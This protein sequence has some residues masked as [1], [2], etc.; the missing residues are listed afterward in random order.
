MAYGLSNGHVTDDVTWP[1]RWCEAVRSAI[2][3][4]AWLL[5]WWLP[6][7]I[8]LVQTLNQVQSILMPAMYSMMQH[9]L[10]FI[11]ISLCK[12]G[13]FMF[14]F[15]TARKLL[16]LVRLSAVLMCSANCTQF[17]LLCD[18][19]F[20][21]ILWKFCYFCNLV[22]LYLCCWKSPTMSLQNTPSYPLIRLCYFCLFG[23]VA[24]A[25]GSQWW[26]RC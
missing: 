20:H 18:D 13:H 17:V 12:W 11:F 1:Q 26:S 4:T 14:D 22:T 6:H 9:V 2:L 16:M 24:S 3:A 19:H 7:A 5:V 10:Q 8:V 15:F 23:L 21:D 25:A